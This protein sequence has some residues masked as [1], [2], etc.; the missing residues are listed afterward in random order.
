MK[1]K[2]LAEH[3][4][5]Q[6]PPVGSSEPS[7]IPTPIS[8]AE[9]FCRKFLDS[10]EYRDSLYRRVLLDDLSSPIECMIWDRAYGQVTKRLEVRDTTNQ[11]ENMTVEQLEE[12]ALFLAQVARR[13]RDEKIEEVR[14]AIH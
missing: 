13:L 9:E 5:A 8:T 7:P 4:G 11:L 14:A 6:T 3:L 12:R 2:S 1:P 10:K